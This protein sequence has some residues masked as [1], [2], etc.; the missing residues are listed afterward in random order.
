MIYINLVGHDLV[1]EVYELIKVFYFDKEIIF[2]EDLSEYEKGLLVVNRLT[3]VNGK[4][5][6]RTD[7]YEDNGLI[8]KG[9]VV[10]IDEV[11]VDKSSIRKKI[12]IGIKQSIYNALL[13]ISNVKAPWGIL[14]GIRPVKIVHN[15]LDENKS[16]QEIIGILTKQYR[17]DL[18]KAQLILDI[19]KKQRK[20]L[21]PLTNNRF[22]LYISIPFCPT[23]C[24]YCSFPSLNINRYRDKVDD[25]IDKL[26]YE[27]ERVGEI[28]SNKTITTVYIG[29]GTPSAISTSQLERV[30]QAVYENFHEDTIKEFTVEAG[31][32]DTINNCM[33]KMLK[34][35]RIDRIS[36]NPQTM[37][38]STLKLIG[39]HHSSQD[40]I[41]TYYDAR[42][43]GFDVINMDLIVGLPSEGLK[44]I[45]YTL[46]IVGK[47]S[48]ENL[49]VH[50]LSIKRGS[51]FINTMDRYKN[52]MKGQ[53]IIEDMLRET[54]I[55]AK[56]KGL[57]PYYLYRQKQI[58]GN[59]ENIGYAK[60]GKEC[61]Y[62]IKMM[63]EKETVIG[64]GMGAVSKIYFPEEDRIERVPNVKSLEEY[65]ER[66]E[67][68]VNRKALI[69]S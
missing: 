9:T 10:D 68:M 40:I 21:Y 35:N 38:D 7:I 32:P 56:E 13:S 48:P 44:E 17:L 8:L 42:E 64:L 26:I 23:R 2:V 58:M 63:E 67:E 24:L 31:R 62:N 19:G 29:G 22:S 55:F 43:I 30:I 51:K 41:S 47:L 57:L 15:L 20:Y 14:T 28:M 16:N 3:E 66:V 65:L 61:I 46:D 4:L 1:N 5:E 50:T 54:E 36:I 18:N 12:R 52:Q 34:E 39:R 37:N 49:T 11:K 45:Q 60:E 59:F 27:I 25:Y 6:A 53:N 33:L 69:L